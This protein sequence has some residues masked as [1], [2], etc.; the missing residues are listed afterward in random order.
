MT[1]IAG[2]RERVREEP[3]PGE[4]H[5]HH[6]LSDEKANIRQCIIKTSTTTKRSVSEQDKNALALTD[7]RWGQGRDV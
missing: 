5:M 4:T 1:W 7:L 3:T 6:V 2:K